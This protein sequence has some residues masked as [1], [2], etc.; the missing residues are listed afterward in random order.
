MYFAPGNIY[1]ESDSRLY[2]DVPRSNLFTLAYVLRVYHSS[3]FSALDPSLFLHQIISLPTN[4][5]H[6]PPPHSPT[7]PTAPLLYSHSS[8][9]LQK[10]PPMPWASTS[11]HLLPPASLRCR[12]LARSYRLKHSHVISF[13]K[14]LCHTLVLFSYASAILD[15]FSPSLAISGTLTSSSSFLPKAE[16]VRYALRE[17]ERGRESLRR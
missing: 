8:S 5:H 10:N 9:A 3:F 14:L 2:L 16:T 11:A 4:D 12:H 7:L 13:F 1:R 15:I 17:R 6:L